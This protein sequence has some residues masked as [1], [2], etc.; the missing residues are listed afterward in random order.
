[1]F[2]PGDRPRKCVRCG[3]VFGSAAFQ[4][5][6]AHPCHAVDDPHERFIAAVREMRRLQRAW[7][8]GDKSTATLEAAK[9]AEREVDAQ[10][11]ELGGAQQR[12]YR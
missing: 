6:K 11:R 4:N 9:R 7:F 5:P 12:L 8:G 2:G 1:M 10:L 3:Q